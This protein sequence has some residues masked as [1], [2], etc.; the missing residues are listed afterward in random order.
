MKGFIRILEAILASILLLTVLSF[1]FTVPQIKTNWADSKTAIEM[2]DSLSSLSRMD[3]ITKAVSEYNPLILNKNLSVM[4]SRSVDFSIDVE[5]IPNPI[6]LVACADCNPTDEQNLKDLLS[7]L[8][9]YYKNRSIEIR[10]E[11]SDLNDFA[12][13]V[14]LVKPNIL[15]VHGAYIPD[16][17]S[18]KLS[19]RKFLQNGG[20]VFI[21][22][23]LA[24][25]NYVNDPFITEL[26][27]ATYT[28]PD[29]TRNFVF[30][31]AQN[32]S[33][34][35]Y[36]INKYYLDISNETFITNDFENV[37]STNVVLKDVKSVFGNN[38]GKSVIYANTQVSLNGKAIFFGPMNRD[39]SVG[40][41]LKASLMWGSERYNFDCTVLG[42]QQ[43][44][45]KTPAKIYN[46][47]K[48]LEAGNYYAEPF[49]IIVKYW[50]VFQ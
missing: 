14:T 29:G 25:N 15:F 5:G 12:R 34:V 20:S 4:L 42:P 46:E 8:Q 13:N 21:Y 39:K 44:I 28:D 9:F 45:P 40:N 35:S 38:N 1:F 41:L 50:V 49:T 26:L 23:N 10:V 30:T 16:L 2:Q 36:K 19:V 48:Y 47:L 43:C 37:T 3:I 6:I 32:P 18:K 33:N 17:I 27:N 7:P 22:G 31:D 11:T 24:N